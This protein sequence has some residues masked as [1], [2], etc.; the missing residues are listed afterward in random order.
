ML[1][2]KKL[3]MMVFSIVFCGSLVAGEEVSSEKVQ[4]IKEQIEIPAKE[5]VAEDTDDS[6]DDT[7]DDQDDEE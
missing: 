2:N 6:D 3:F 7:D 4:V 5:E 1:L